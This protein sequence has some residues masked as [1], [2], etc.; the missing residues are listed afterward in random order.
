MLYHLAGAGSVI[1]PVLVAV[2]ELLLER[3]KAVAV[4]ALVC[5][6]VVPWTAGT[7][8]GVE[9]AKAYGSFL[10]SDAG[11]SLGRWPHT[12]AL[13]LLFPTA[14]AGTALWG[15]ARVRA[16]A[17]RAQRDRRRGIR[18]SPTESRHSLAGR[19]LT[20]PVA[21]AAGLA[22]LGV[23][24]WCSLHSFTR[25]MLEID[26]CSQQGQWGAVLRTAGRL[27]RDVYHV[28]CERNILLALYHLGRLG[29]EMCR[30]AL[31][32]TVD[33]FCTPERHQDLGSYYQESRLLLDIGQVN[34]AEKCAFE[35][36]ETSGDQPA[37]LEQLAT[38]SMVKGRPET[39]RVFLRALARNPFQRRSAQ[40]LRGR[41]DT[42]PGLEH[43]AQVSQL[44][45]NAVDQDRV[46]RP[47]NLEAFLIELLE[48]NPRNRLAFELLM[49]H[50]L[51]AG[52]LERVAENLGRLKDFSYRTVP[53]HYQEAWLIHAGF[54]DRPPP[55]PGFALD[56]EVVRAAQEFRRITARA[57]G[58]QDAAQQAWVAGLG[59]S[60][61][62]YYLANG[63][64]GR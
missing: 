18:S 45:A 28:R 31:K 41:L 38:I 34:E 5:G 13:Y 24:A 22:I 37:V 1:F 10:V 59:D 46:V 12:L 42:D 11:V 14:L 6:G 3:R 29:D 62:L 23:L 49:A 8:F 15:A 4:V 19:L 35:A 21:A 48:K 51:A 60:Y 27:P 30:Y 57:A 25:T 52:R 61:F 20:W 43:D 40:A 9:P 33:L 26:Y 54:P 53:R 32:P 64:S 58:A 36:L 44:R 63:S 2:D 7:W 39:A 50:Y 47:A 55:I 17:P 16:G 56:P